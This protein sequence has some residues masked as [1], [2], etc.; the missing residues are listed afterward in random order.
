MSVRSGLIG[1]AAATALA[2]LGTASAAVMVVGSGPERTCYEAAKIARA[3]GVALASCDEALNGDQLSP[4]DRAATYT[5]R[6]VLLLVRNS[7]TAALSDTNRALRIEPSMTAA[8]VNRSAALILM[9]R[10]QEARETIDQA[11]PLA[12][13][14]ELQRA[15]FNRALANEA[16]G[17]IKAAYRDLKRAVELDPQ[18]EEA[19]TELARYQVR[20]K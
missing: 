5:N 10:Y 2:A 4:H 9:E 20:S 12:S 7:A 8:S 6:S 16:L 14:M 15:L 11:L 17:D 1:F 19:K 13:G 3:S 18:F